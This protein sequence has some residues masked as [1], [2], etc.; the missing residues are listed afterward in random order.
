MHKHAENLSEKHVISLISLSAVASLLL[1]VADIGVWGY[2]V[3]LM[4]YA[5]EHVLYP[6]MSEVLNHRAKEHQRATILSVASFFRTLPYIV[7]APVIGYLNTRDNLEYF[8]VFW[9]LL[10]VL[11]VLLYL[12]LKMKDI[13]ISLVEKE[14]EEGL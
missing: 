8:L 14:P 1:A 6:F 11:A 10:I 7:L 13:H 12:S 2:A 5:G 9:A 3:I 4:L